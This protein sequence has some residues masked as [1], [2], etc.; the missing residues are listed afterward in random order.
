[1]K[2]LVAFML[3]LVCLVAYAAEDGAPVAAVPAVRF[4]AVD[5]Y[6]DSGAT[7]LAAYQFELKSTGADVKIVGIEGGDH[8]AFRKA[9]Y[10]DPAALSKARVI[11][12]AFDTGNG[13]PAGKTRVARVH[14][15]VEGAA[16][17]VHTAI[18][19][20]AGNAQGKRI[21]A[22]ISVSKGEIK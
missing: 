14:V 3:I 17:P 6:I 11:I 19:A 5:V 2:R 22:E 4:E 12:A 21:T 1:M 10:Y 8:A 16:E 18:L 7:P 15:R 20:L 13:L 9:P